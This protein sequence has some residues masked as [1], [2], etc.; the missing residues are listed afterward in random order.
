MTIK[1]VYDSGAYSAVNMNNS[2]IWH[3]RLGHIGNNEF[4]QSAKTVDRM[5]VK[6]N[7]DVPEVCETCVNGKQ[8]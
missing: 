8:T 4:Q 5:N 1:E 6:T 2:K 7:S 3:S